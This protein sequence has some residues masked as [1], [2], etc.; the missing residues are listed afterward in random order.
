MFSIFVI[1]CIIIL[2][3]FFLFIY[4]L[5]SVW[6]HKCFI[7]VVCTLTISG[8]TYIF[9]ILYFPDS[10]TIIFAKCIVISILDSK[11]YWISTFIYTLFI[12]CHFYV[13][14][15][16]ISTLYSLW[17]FINIIRYN[18]PKFTRFTIIYTIII[19]FGR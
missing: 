10:I 5:I 2:W 16:Y 17:T 3:T 18:I 9:T 6:Y 7:F 12:I 1:T 11:F 15:I 19:W 8:N 14:W 4:T 13:I